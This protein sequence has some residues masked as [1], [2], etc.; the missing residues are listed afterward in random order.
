MNFVKGIFSS[1]EPEYNYEQDVQQQPMP[2][3]PMCHQEKRGVCVRVQCEECHGTGKLN[4][5]EYRPYC[6]WCNGIGVRFENQI[7]CKNCEIR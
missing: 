6:D 4:E 5:S 1:E 3:C 7:R 2:I